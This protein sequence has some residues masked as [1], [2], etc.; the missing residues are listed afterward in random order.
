MKRSAKPVRRLTPAQ[1]QRVR[2][3]VED[4]GDTREAAVA[5]V[6][7]FEPD[8]EEVSKSDGRVVEE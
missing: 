7:A 6:L 5:W 2:E 1:R 4:G 8:A 3:L